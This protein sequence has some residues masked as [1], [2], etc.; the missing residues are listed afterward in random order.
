MAVPALFYLALNLPGARPRWVGP[1]P[2]PPTS[3]SP[4]PCWPSSAP[5]SRPRC[6]SSCS[7]SPWSMTCSPSPSSRSFTPPTCTGCRSPR[8][9]CHW[10]CSRC[11]YSVGCAPGGYCSP[12][13]WPRGSWCTSPASTPPSRVYC[14]D[15][16][17]RSTAAPPAPGPGWPSTSNTASAPSR[18]GWPCRC[19]RSSPQACPCSTATGPRPRSPTPSPSASSPGSCSANPSACSQ[20]PGSC[21][22]SPAPDSPTACPG[23]TSSDWLCCPGSGSPSPC[24]SANSPSA[25]APRRRPRQDRRTGRIAAGRARCRRRPTDPQRALPKHVRRGGTRRSRHTAP[26]RVPG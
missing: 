10:E 24:S 16:P 22:A 3:H 14:S 18:P 1:S 17:S 2:P 21:S 20:A 7:P 12:S 25:P 26:T 13:P 15:S 19:S 11:W 4:W 5:T 8:Q 6:G 23:G 9:C